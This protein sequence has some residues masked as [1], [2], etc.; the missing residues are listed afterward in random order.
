MKNETDSK[1]IADNIRAERNRANITIETIEKELKISRPTYVEYEKDAE[2]IK[3][4]TL[5]KLAKLFN[6]SITRFFIQN[7][8]TNC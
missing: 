7:D 5:I 1:K 8:L 2:K 4:G 3:V 6:C